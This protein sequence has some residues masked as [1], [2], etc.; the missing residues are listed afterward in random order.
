MV[1]KI[2]SCHYYYC[3]SL[4][5]LLVRVMMDSCEATNVV[6][7]KLMNFDP[8]NANR[9]M[10]ILL[11]ALP[12]SELIRLSHSPDHVL[13]AFIHKVKAN[14]G[15]ARPTSSSNP[16]SNGFDFIR[17]NNNNNPSSPSSPF[18]GFPNNPISPN[19]NPLL[20]YKNIRSR[21]PNNPPNAVN[22]FVDEQQLND[23]NLA[24][25]SLLRVL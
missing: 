13:H 14:L 5:L 23:H 20:S 11:I 15:L 22:D 2:M 8:E 24:V 12:Q 6:L 21:F 7:A 17:N 9:I 18:S 25:G 16:F 1:N 10:G 19:F 3:H 4:L